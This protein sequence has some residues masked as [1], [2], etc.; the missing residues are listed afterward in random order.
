[1]IVGGGGGGDQGVG[2]MRGDGESEVALGLGSHAGVSVTPVAGYDLSGRLL[3][4][5]GH[6]PEVARVLYQLLDF[7]GSE[8]YA[9][10]GGPLVGRRFEDLL[11]AFDQAV[12]VGIFLPAAE[13][14][15]MDVNSVDYINFNALS[16]GN[17]GRRVLL[18]PPPD[19]V[20]RKGESL[21][22]VAR[23]RFSFSPD[24]E[25]SLAIQSAMVDGSEPLNPSPA[26]KERMLKGEVGAAPLSVANNMFNPKKILVTWRNN[27]EDIIVEIDRWAA[28]GSSLTIL[29][30][31]PV[32]PAH[33]TRH[34]YLHQL[35]TMQT[36]C[37]P[38]LCI[39]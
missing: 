38:F 37:L 27:M 35:A 9:T 18:N 7:S 15:E 30:P 19:R 24:M 1:V 25:Q 32:P 34:Y 31:L 17:H 10:G 21:V 3:V 26:L 33:D 4:Q 28:P 20:L 13:R 39:Q 14:Q 36:M 2:E 22:V 8:F 23:T 29:S 16:L 6:A 12:P 11:F 5:A